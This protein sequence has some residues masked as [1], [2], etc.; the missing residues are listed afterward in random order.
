MCS[1]DVFTVVLLLRY[2][3]VMDMKKLL[4]LTIKAEMAYEHFLGVSAQAVIDSYSANSSLDSPLQVRELL[5]KD[6]SFMLLGGAPEET[7]FSD[8]EM[9]DLFSAQSCVESCPRVVEKLG[10]ILARLQA[11]ERVD[12]D[13]LIPYAREIVCAVDELSSG[14]GEHSDAF[15]SSFDKAVVESLSDIDADNLG[16]LIV[17]LG[18]GQSQK[19]LI[20]NTMHSVLIGTKLNETTS[21]FLQTLQDESQEFGAL[22]DPKTNTLLWGAETM[23]VDISADIAIFDAYQK[24]GFQSDVYVAWRIDFIERV[25]LA[26]GLDKYK[27]QGKQD[28][29]E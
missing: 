17:S 8:N 27:E 18:L 15:N 11:G 24:I 29:R 6:L 5:D 23:P 1:F 3:L 13:S 16:D 2:N 12:P 10:E 26:L 4:E 25:Y 14:S 20:N 7:Y 21:E 19:E 22:S 28:D 9:P